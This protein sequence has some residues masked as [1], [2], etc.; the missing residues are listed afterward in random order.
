MQLLRFIQLFR[1]K[2]QGLILDSP[3]IPHLNHQSVLS[4]YALKIYLQNI[5]WIW[6]FLTF[7]TVYPSPDTI[8]YKSMVYYI[9]FPSLLFCSLIA[10]FWDKAA[11][12]IKLELELNHVFSPSKPS[13]GFSSHLKI[14]PHILT[15]AYKIVP[16]VGSSLLA[17]SAPP[18]PLCST[19]VFLQFPDVV[20]LFPT[21]ESHFCLFFLQIFILLTP[22]HS[23]CWPNM[24]FKKGNVL[25]PLSPPHY[26]LFLLIALV[27]T[28]FPPFLF[29]K[30][31]FKWKIDVT[32]SHRIKKVNNTDEIQVLFKYLS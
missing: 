12:M 28:Y 5:L 22:S 14:K 16:K 20:M 3:Y 24:T 10:P 4:K 1:P 29:I 21:S 15:M 30:S 6:P 26:S 18:F 13:N 31:I 8:F 25:F 19:L 7:S 32:A 2:Y 11:K 9:W 17:D 27:S 23:D